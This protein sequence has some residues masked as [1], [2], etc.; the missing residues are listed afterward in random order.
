MTFIAGLMFAVFLVSV[1]W[2]VNRWLCNGKLRCDRYLLLLTASAVFVLAVVL[3]SA[4]NPVYEA[5]FGHKLWEYRV[6]PLHDA[7]VSALGAAL[8]FAYGIHLYFTLQSLRH[9]LPGPLNGHHGKALVIGVEAPLFA[10]VTGNL[11]FLAIAGQYYAYYVPG[12][13]LHLTSL[14][15]IPVYA[16]CV[17][18]GLH[19]L[20]RLERLPRHTLIPAGLFTTGV[21]FL[22]AG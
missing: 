7:N 18:L 13:L 10:E 16:V 21:V 6:L 14:Q 3:E 19:A 11:I 8:W 15:A 2:R 20:E 5:L 12:D 4:F 17:Y 22:L 9:R 1:S